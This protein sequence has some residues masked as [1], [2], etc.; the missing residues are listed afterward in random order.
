MKILTLKDFDEAIELIEEVTGNKQL[1]ILTEQIGLIFR[2][3]RS[4]QTTLINELLEMYDSASEHNID[5]NR[6]A[7]FQLVQRLASTTEVSE[8]LS[9]E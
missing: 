8:D 2:T 4:R 7:I 5:V 3:F 6:Q 1:N 9:K